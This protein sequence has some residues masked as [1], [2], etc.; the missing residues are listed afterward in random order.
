MQRLLDTLLRHVLKI[1]RTEE[2][3]TWLVCLWSLFLISACSHSDRQMVDRLNDVSYAYH[4]RNL[5]SASYYAR[6]A[7]IN[8]GDYDA[9]KAE[10]Y[11]NYAFVSI[12]RMEYDKAMRQLDSVPLFTDNQIELLV[13]DVLQMRLCQRMSR[14]KEFYDY[15]ERAKK[16]IE[17][18]SEDRDRLD[19]R[20][21]LRLIYAESE[22]A[23]VSSTYFHYIG[24]P[25]KS[26]EALYEIDSEGDIRRDTAQ[27]LN[28][29]YNVG[30]GGIISGESSHDINIQEF[31]YLVKCLLMAR[32]SGMHY[33][34]ANALSS[35][36][37]HLIIKKIG[38]LLMD[39][40]RAFF[41]YMYPDEVS[42]D[43][44]A[45]LFAGEA[46]DIFRSYGDI[47][48]ISG[49]HRTL[50]S[51][52]HATGNDKEA[53][54]HLR[55]A[56]AEPKIKQ[57]PDLVASI[58]EQLSVVYSAMDDKPSSDYY[59][60]IYLDLQEQTRQDKYLEARADMYNAMAVQLNIMIA[61]VLSAILLLVFLLWR[62]SNLY[63][64]RRRSESI[65]YLLEPLRQWEMDNQKKQERLSE[66]YEYLMEQCAISNAHIEEE[67]R[68]SLENRAKVSL[69]LSIM[70]FIDR[71]INEADKLKERDESS[72]I[73]MS[74]YTYICEL[75][76]KIDEYNDVLTHWI[77]MRKGILSIHIES[78]CLRE[79][80]DIV[81]KSKT[82]FA[83]SGITLDV[84]A[85]E[86]D[87][88]VKAD[89]I[90]TLFMINTLT[91]NARKVTPEGGNVSVYAAVEAEYVEI[92]VADTGCGLSDAEIKAIFNRK[93]YSGGNGF[94]LMNCM[95]IIE[96]YRKLSN[97]FSVCYMSAE[98][99]TG[100][101]SRFFFRLP[102]GMINTVLFVLVLL[103]AWLPC[104]AWSENDMHPDAGPVN[105]V[106]YN[107]VMAHAFADSAYYSNIRGTYMQT[108][109][110]ADSCRKYLNARYLEL[111]PGGK[112]KMQRMGKVSLLA[113]EIKW[114]RDSLKTSYETILL[115]RNESAVAALALHKW[116]LYIYNNRV[117][118]LLFK[119]M[120]ADNTLADYCRMMSLSQ[121]NK[122]IAVTLLILILILIL[123][124]Y[125]FLYYRHRLYYK[126]C[127][128]QVKSINSLLA[129]GLTPE[130]KLREIDS[131]RPD[132]YPDSLRS[133]V[134]QIKSSLRNAVEISEDKRMRI[135][136]AGDELS[137]TEYESGNLYVS[138][139]I[140][141]NCLS[142]LKHET[143]YYPSRLIQLA[144][145]SE[146]CIG[147]IK[148]LV[149]YYHELYT[150]LSM[151]AMRQVKS[152]KIDVAS[153][154]LKNILPRYVVYGGDD[155]ILL[156]NK[157]LLAY[158]FDIL[159]RLS[160]Y[161][162]MA[163]ND[164]CDCTKG[165]YVESIGNAYVRISINMPS[166]R[167]SADEVACL[168]T[169]SKSRIKYL[170]CR[171]IVR[172]HSEITNRRGCGISARSDDGIIV[173]DVVLPKRGGKIKS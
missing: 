90:L 5:D 48:Q 111:N 115:M 76:E 122:T 58:S 129:S 52:C 55:E 46:L 170:L 89:K 32:N 140:L 14:N 87:V 18:I 123:P 135:E 83:M 1:K 25:G 6:Q 146:R 15:R 100:K 88:P 127:V 68:R 2:G 104:P 114:Y 23:I 101:G 4:Y 24:L 103:A 26:A 31:E 107:I 130:E 110:F 84:D 156:G 42:V 77:Q 149:D 134:L 56:L 159:F 7:Y 17:R 95:G 85:G 19:D 50:A 81:A 43:T 60:N 125:Y 137:R 22:Y 124:A 8:S 75:A 69:V 16:R 37:E 61:A 109:S 27:Y 45:Y 96:K 71:I 86:A 168:F 157:E 35:M 10:A 13:A 154:S 39:D 63:R 144:S 106:P 21:L 72:E 158:L 166:L 155:V 38:D 112:Y 138:N 66:E 142:T 121:T 73:R 119:E 11:N 105:P 152:M 62:F 70:P 12:A 145:G 148:E 169:P 118:T 116:D 51:C 3:F 133:I 91:D 94:G 132:S 172:D 36:S 108:I 160:G 99:R 98:S 120:S 74:R 67:K 164:I 167:L 126:F 153:V 41:S 28:Y 139:S 79:L 92:S 171:Q 82:A 165:L 141:D 163:A 151:Q 49:A 65:D 64:K 78:F 93:T 30:A 29:L 97:I 147:D 47:Y 80:F 150:L 40:N 117:Y 128:E 20:T 53:L 33:F 59:R 131:Y 44:V 34:V 57:A 113:P 54:L 136:L 161:R 102:K 162:D 9:G 143:M 173:V